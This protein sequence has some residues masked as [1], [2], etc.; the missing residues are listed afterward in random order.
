M[1]ASASNVWV[2]T[3][4][5]AA[6]AFCTMLANATDMQVTNVGDTQWVPLEANTLSAGMDTYIDMGSIQGDST[7]GTVRLL[8]S[9]DKFSFVWLVGF[10][11]QTQG[12]WLNGAVITYSGPF[13]SGKRYI[14][15]NNISDPLPWVDIGRV[16]YLKTARRLV[17]LN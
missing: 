17:C 5:A 10:N 8:H 12:Q 13:Q 9:N 15:E 14:K 7:A 2:K 16:N 6:L 3:V 1:N 4:M 11:C